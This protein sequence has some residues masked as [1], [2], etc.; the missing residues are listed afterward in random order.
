MDNGRNVMDDNYLENVEILVKGNQYSVSQLGIDLIQQS[1][2][3]GSNDPI[4]EAVVVT[5]RMSGLI[6]TEMSIGSKNRDTL[7]KFSEHLTLISNFES[8]TENASRLC[9]CEEEDDNE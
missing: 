3:A 1:N 8:A 2:H 9:G 7:A 5:R 6:E 4:I